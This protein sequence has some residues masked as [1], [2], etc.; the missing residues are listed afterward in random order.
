V[1]KWAQSVLVA[2]IPPQPPRPTQPP[3]LSR[4]E[5]E[6]QSGAVVLYDQQVKAGM[7]HPICG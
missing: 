7:A 5:N 2:S 1:H 3:T 4:K 6:Y